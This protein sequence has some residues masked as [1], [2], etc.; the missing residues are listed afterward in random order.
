MVYE[1]RR[2]FWLSW[3]G[4]IWNIH[5]KQILDIWAVD[6]GIFGDCVDISTLNSLALCSLGVAHVTRQIRST[7]EA[8]TTNF[9]C[10][11]G[12]D[13]LNDT[14]YKTYGFVFHSITVKRHEDL[15]YDA[16]IWDATTAHRKDLL[17]VGYR[18][19]PTYHEPDHSYWLLLGY[20]Q[21]DF[22]GERLGLVASNEDVWDPI[23]SFGYS[24]E[25][26]IAIP[27]TVPRY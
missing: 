18:N 21:T 5:L 15:W 8:F 7:D 24:G 12:S 1:P 14:K 25:D 11:M 10:P 6:L 17:G 13:P 2:N 26:W 20:W 23:R 16:L 9:L 22:G 19:P 3:D 4:N 27:I